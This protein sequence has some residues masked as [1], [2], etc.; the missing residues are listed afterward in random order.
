MREKLAWTEGAGK[1]IAHV[2]LGL[3]EKF[4]SFFSRKVNGLPMRKIKTG[5][6]L[7]CVCGGSLSF[8][9]IA[10]AVRGNKVSESIR[11]QG[12]TVPVLVE[13]GE[14]KNISSNILSEGEYKK[15]VGFKKFMDSLKRNKDSLYDQILLERPGLMDSILLLEKI[16]LSNNKK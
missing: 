3:Q 15:I 7:F 12:I 6:I 5:L 14:K 16:Y 8:Y 9:W 11:V 1:K 10:V 4:S 13:P 2:A